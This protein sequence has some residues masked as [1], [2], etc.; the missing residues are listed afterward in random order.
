MKKTY[1]PFESEIAVSIT[2]GAERGKYRLPA[3]T[4]TA[5]GRTPGQPYRSRYNFL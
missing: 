1:T 2:N 5:V 3:T 4:N